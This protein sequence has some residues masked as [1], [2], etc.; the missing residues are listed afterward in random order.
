VRRGTWH[1]MYYTANRFLAVATVA[2]L[3]LAIVLLPRA[4]AALEPQRV[5][6]PGGIEAWLIQDDS[7]P[8]LSLS[9]AF[10][11]GA[12]EQPEGL[13]GVAA[14]AMSLLTEGAGEYDS[15]AFQDA[16]A[17]HSIELSFSASQDRLSGAL[18]TLTRHQ[19]KAFSL[20]RQAMTEPR[21]D[22]DAVERLRQQF[23][24]VQARRAQDPSTI[25]WRT[26]YSL[27]F[28][29]HPYA[30]PSEGTPESLGA[31]E[32][33][34]LRAYV[35]EQLARDRLYVAAAGD[36]DPDTL[37][38][39]LDET[40]GPLPEEGA[41]FQAQEVTPNAEG[42]LLIVER[43]QPQSNVVLG[44]AG[45]ARDDPD[46]IA[47][48][49]VNHV[50]GGSTF[51]SRLFMQVR[52]ERGLAYSVYTGLS[53]LDKAPL[54]VGGV[55]SENARVAEALGLI[56]AEWQRLGEEGPTEEELQTAK[57]YLLGSF[58]LSLSSSPRISNTLLQ[59]QLDDLGID[60]MERRQELIEAVTL[61]DAR[62]VAKRLLDADALTVV[63]VGKPGGLVSTREPPGE[64]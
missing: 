31:I 9:F 32:I 13:E 4:A 52:E 53:T 28:G 34:D 44:H 24:V 51:S 49:L 58:A 33:E 37:G 59:L 60:Y 50:L 55:G 29:N 48:T 11:G 45:I 19:D 18:L 47:A 25:A 63:V 26:L 5:V 10:R 15:E 42:G 16:L 6:S 1:Q 2:S 22:P 38:R 57:D 46:F 40:F 20:L 61:E 3:S 17:D 56:Q 64:S 7:N 54:L 36:I 62:R 35:G 23:Q 27:L 30:R 39:L 43:D 8:L 14:L 21:F 12:A 41:A